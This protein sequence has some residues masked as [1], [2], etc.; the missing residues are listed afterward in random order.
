MLALIML[1]SCSSTAHA[2][3]TSFLFSY[4]DEVYIRA[5]CGHGHCSRCWRS[6]RACFTLIL[7]LIHDRTLLLSYSTK[8]SVGFIPEPLQDTIFDS[9]LGRARNKLS[10]LVHTAGSC[11]SKFYK[12][13][14]KLAF[15][16]TLNSERYQ[17]HSLLKYLVTMT[18]SFL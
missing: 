10:L 13:V 15:A 3:V 16:R 11:T 6:S 18:T 12:R 4:M 14:L 9:I 17:Q 7:H 2:T 1:V 8:I 5:Q